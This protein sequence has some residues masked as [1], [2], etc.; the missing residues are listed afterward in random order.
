MH[1][2]PNGNS[3]RGVGRPT[4]RTPAVAKRILDAIAEGFPLEAAVRSAGVG[5]VFFATWRIEDSDFDRRVHEAEWI[6][7]RRT[8]KLIRDAAKNGDW[9]AAAW[10]MERRHPDLY[11]RPE[12]QLQLLQQINVNGAGSNTFMIEIARSRA[13]YERMRSDDPRWQA[14]E[15]FAERILPR[16][17]RRNGTCLSASRQ[18]A[19]LGGF[20]GG[21]F[22]L[23]DPFSDQ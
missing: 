9:K 13:E 16:F 10:L 17:D 11:S 15:N 5:Y 20:L 3:K 2:S 4:K 7:I 23:A 21:F 6:N 19:F 22:L 12:I 14:C 8:I 1:A 18:R